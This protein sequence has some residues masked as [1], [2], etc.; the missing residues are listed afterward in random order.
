MA[1]IQFTGSIKDTRN[2]HQFEL[3][4]FSFIDEGV[5]IIYSPALDLSGYGKTIA[6]A[7]VSFELTLEEFVR[8]SS[9]KKSLQKELK[10][11]G[12]EIKKKSKPYSA[13]ELSLML[14]KNDYLANIFETK[15][16]KKYNETV[17]LPFA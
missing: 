16:F 11:L 14:Q 2:I 3:S 13:P 4:L 1:K 7:K 17:A 8:Y 15:D 6:E 5:R 10:R 9:N 12:W